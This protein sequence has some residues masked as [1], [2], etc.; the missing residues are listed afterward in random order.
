MNEK[1]IE[2]TLKKIDEALAG[3]THKV[4]QAYLDDLKKQSREIRKRKAEEK[5]K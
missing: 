3:K 1:E 2:Y 4:T 5:K